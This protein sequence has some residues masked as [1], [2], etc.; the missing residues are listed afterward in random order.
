MKHAELYAAFPTPGFV[1][2]QCYGTLNLMWTRPEVVF[3]GTPAV[4]EKHEIALYLCLQC[5]RSIS[6]DRTTS[7]IRNEYQAVSPVSEAAAELRATIAAEAGQP[8][9]GSQ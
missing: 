1:A 9:G 4:P 3:A 8:Q 2:S 6:F 5:G 7:Q